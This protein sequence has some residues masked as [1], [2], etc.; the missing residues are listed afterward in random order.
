MVALG[1]HRD[2][3]SVRRTRSRL[4]AGSE[5]L[6]WARGIRASG[7]RTENLLTVVGQD[8]ACTVDLE[9]MERTSEGRTL[10]RTLRCTQVYRLEG[11]RW[12]VIVRHADELA[13]KDAEQK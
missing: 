2:H 9:H 11:G 3:G 13:Q 1:R 10:H 8:L 5:R 7:R 6:E 4:A 12:K